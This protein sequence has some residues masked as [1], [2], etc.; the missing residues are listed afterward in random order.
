MSECPI[1]SLIYLV[2]IPDSCSIVANVFLIIW[3]LKYF[4][5]QYLQSFRSVLSSDLTRPVS[6]PSYARYWFLYPHLA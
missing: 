4:T 3:V 5:S 2:G 1:R 6:L